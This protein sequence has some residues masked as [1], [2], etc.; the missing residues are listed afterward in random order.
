GVIG[1]NADADFAAAIGVLQGVVQQVD[2]DTVHLQPV[3]PQLDLLFSAIAMKLNA[4]AGSLVSEFGGGFADDLAN[5]RQ[6]GVGPDGAAVFQ[7]S[8]HQLVQPVGFSFDYIQKWFN[9]FAVFQLA[10]QGAQRSGGAAQ[11]FAD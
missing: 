4:L 6:F 1:G 3:E 8:L 2:E 5:V 11:W 7:Q 9:G 10:L